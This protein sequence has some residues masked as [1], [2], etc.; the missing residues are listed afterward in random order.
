LVI[1]GIQIPPDDN[2][3]RFCYLGKRIQAA[4]FHALKAVSLIGETYGNRTPLEIESPTL[5]PGRFNLPDL[6]P[7]HLPAPAVLSSLRRATEVDRQLRNLGVASI[8][9]HSKCR[10]T[11]RMM[12]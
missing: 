12:G 2:G 4:F 11:E 1:G 10:F 9:S 8:E 6:R 3:P 5:P 7:A